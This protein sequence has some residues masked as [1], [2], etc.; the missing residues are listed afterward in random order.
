MRRTLLGVAGF[1]VGHSRSP[2]M[3]NAALEELGLDWLY[4]PLPLPPE[5]FDAAVR[6]LP[7]SG[8]RGINVTVPHKLAAHDLADYRTAA[9]GAIGAANT[10]T[11]ADGAV[12]ADNTDAAGFLDALGESPRGWRALVLGAGGSARAVAWA[13][14][15][16]GA[17]VAVLNRTRERA[18]ALAADLGIRHAERPDAE[19]LIVNCTSV[20]LDPQTDL[21][22]ALGAVG[23]AGTKPPAVF[24]DL[25]YGSSRTPL[26]EWAASGGSRTV[27]GLEVLVRQG[28]RSLERWTGQQPPLELMRRAAKNG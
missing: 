15:E 23:L 27:E 8:F 26:V 2:A 6:A 12:H 24:A 9:A 18:A 17:D 10:L 16:E 4:L 7:G 11:F 1:P 13:L 22:V 20:G 5:R 14:R 3:H 21:D 19:D 28:A 25:V